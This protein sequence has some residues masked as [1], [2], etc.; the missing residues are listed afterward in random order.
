MII[1]PIS[2]QK[3]NSRNFSTYE[4]NWA[5]K[6][7]AAL[8]IL[9]LDYAQFMPLHSINRAYILSSKFNAID[10]CKEK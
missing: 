9:G 6:G 2:I 3:S 10:F 5:A 1:M 7:A 8:L 4:K